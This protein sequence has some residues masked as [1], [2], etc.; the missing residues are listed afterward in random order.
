MEFEFVLQLIEH[1]TLSTVW[2]CF[3]A[4]LHV[5]VSEYQGSEPQDPRYGQKFP[6][7][8]EDTEPEKRRAGFSFSSAGH[9]VDHGKNK[10]MPDFLHLQVHKINSKA[11]RLPLA[12][13]FYDSELPF[14]IILLLLP[15]ICFPSLCG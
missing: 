7:S 10:H 15:R 2:N 8:T 13:I 14:L 6:D 11:L 12:V 4:N 9:W 5:H 3:G 1:C